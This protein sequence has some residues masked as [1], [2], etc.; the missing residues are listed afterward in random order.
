MRF[1]LYFIVPIV[2]SFSFI[3]SGGMDNRPFIKEYN[4][5]HDLM[6]KQYQQ[7]ILLDKLCSNYLSSFH[8][9]KL[10]EEYEK[11][12]SYSLWRDLNLYDF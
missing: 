7:K 9:L 12:Y 5:T 10:I 6:I 4:Q 3:K 1:I 11:S 2:Y 8:K